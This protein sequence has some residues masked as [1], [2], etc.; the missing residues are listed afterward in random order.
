[1]V[2]YFA[3]IQILSFFLHCLMQFCNAFKNL[4]LVYFVTVLGKLVEL[5]LTGF[6]VKRL[7][8]NMDI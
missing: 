4:D 3:L 2:V 6:L 1:M 5:H 8:V 7:G